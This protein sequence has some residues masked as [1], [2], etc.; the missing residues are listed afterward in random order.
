MKIPEKL[1]EKVPDI[2]W[3]KYRNCFSSKKIVPDTICIDTDRKIFRVGAF[4]YIVGYFVH[5]ASEL[6]IGKIEDDATIT[7]F[8]DMD[9]ILKDDF[10]KN[11]DGVSFWTILGGD[12]VKEQFSKFMKNTTYQVK[13][14]R[15][16]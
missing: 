7:L 4:K 15:E 2:F 8:E 6:L 11:V 1:K 16:K 12:S 13:K 3:D 5:Q 14:R 9:E 10:I